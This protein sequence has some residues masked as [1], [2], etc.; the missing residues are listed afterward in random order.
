[1]KILRITDKDGNFL[2]DDFSYD[3]DTEIGMDVEPSKGLTRPRWNGEKWIEGATQEHINSL[4]LTNEQIRLLRQDQ[5]RRRSDTLYLAWKKYEVTGDE[6][7]EQ[8][9]INWLA[10]VHRI[11][12]ELPYL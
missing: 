7:A 3:S 1:M 11:E 4:G 5:Y 8:A 9:K 12:N 10:E 6:R 2:R